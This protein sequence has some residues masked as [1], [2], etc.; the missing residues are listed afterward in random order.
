MAA[1]RKPGRP[2]SFDAATTARVIAL[3]GASVPRRH[4]ADACGISI[5]VMCKWVQRGR[6]AAK[7]DE[8]HVLFYQ[9]LKKAE[10][11]AIAVSVGRIRRAANGG[12][13]LERTTT[14]T[15]G[16][17]GEPVTKVVE[18]VA[19]PVWTADAWLLERRHPGE[20][21]SD[22]RELRDLHR[23]YKSLEDRLLKLTGGTGGKPVGDQTTA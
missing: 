10:A 2:T 21:S 1:K 22:R 3:A 11:E 5:S 16:P 14:T 8:E 12:A 13:V 17:D 18:K 19:Q 23:A 7:G 9:A 6:R 20:F 15:I 4:I